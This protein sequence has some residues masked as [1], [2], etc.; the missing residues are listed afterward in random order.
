MILFKEWMKCITWIMDVSLTNDI[1][2]DPLP[3]GGD[4]K[5]NNR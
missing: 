1:Y 5:L 3:A 2:T 4:I